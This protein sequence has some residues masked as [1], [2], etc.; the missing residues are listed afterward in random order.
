MASVNKCISIIE[1]QVN[2]KG[3]IHCT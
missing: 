3:Y 1:I 2:F